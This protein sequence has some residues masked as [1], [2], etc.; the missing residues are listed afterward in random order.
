ML[1]INDIANNLLY[2]PKKANAP[3]TFLSQIQ[4]EIIAPIIDSLVLEKKMQFK[5]RSIYFNLNIQPNTLE[6]AANINLSEFKRAISNLLD[7]AVESLQENGHIS[8]NLILAA[9]TVNLTIEDN[10]CGMSRVLLDKVLKGGVSTK[11]QGH[12][13]G[14]SQ[15]T[16]C[17][18]SWAG[19]FQIQSQE[20]RG[21]LI[22]ITL[23]IAACP[24]S[25]QELSACHAETII[26]LDDNEALTET[27]KLQG[28]L[29]GKRVL[30]FNQIEVFLQ[31]ITHYAKNIPIYIDSYLSEEIRGEILAKQ[32]FEQGYQNLYLTT[33]Y[34][35][36]SFE[37]M[38]WIKEIVGKEPPF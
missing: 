12:G 13:M 18:S 15:A 33:G 34:E 5:Q 22:S 4:P 14:L 9:N 11:P 1:R 19:Q 36:S 32:L 6:V 38:Y 31:S 7:N 17:I 35:K 21:T 29:C 25:R 28:E 20:N 37:A 27:W 2:F 30:T 16:K 3:I 23:P 26:I 24:N 10:G 8:I